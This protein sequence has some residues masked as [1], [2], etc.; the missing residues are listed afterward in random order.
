M[1]A[2]E[3]CHART[4]PGYPPRS[5]VLMDSCA[6]DVV[7]ALDACRRGEGA[8]TLDQFLRPDPR[9]GLE[10]VDVLREIGEEFALVLEQ[11]DECVG[12][13]KPVAVG[14]EDVLGHGV[15]DRGV[16][17]EERDVKDFLRVRE[18]QMC[19]LGVQTCFLGAEVWDP[20]AGGDAGAG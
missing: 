1:W 10:V 19:E 4:A 6:G 7:A 9:S 13:G 18:P 17:T 5:Q 16:L 12:R 3:P 20:Q 11:A 2:A 15:E 14:G 8:M